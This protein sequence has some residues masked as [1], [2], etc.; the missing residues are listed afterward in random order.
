LLFFDRLYRRRDPI[1]TFNWLPLDYESCKIRA[2]KSPVETKRTSPS[3]AKK[4][5]QGSKKNDGSEVS[6][7]HSN[8]FLSGVSEKV[9]EHELGVNLPQSLGSSHDTK[10][11]LD[12]LYE[13][14]EKAKWEYCIWISTLNRD[15]NFNPRGKIDPNGST[16][17][18]IVNGLKLHF[19]SNTWST[20]IYREDGIYFSW[21]MNSNGHMSFWLNEKLSLELFFRHLQEKLEPCNLTTKEFKALIEGIKH[22]NTENERKRLFKLM[23]K[24]EFEKLK[25][26][27]DSIKDSEMQ[28]LETANII[29]PAGIIARDFNQACLVC[30]KIFFK[31]LYLSVLIKIDKSKGPFEIEFIGPEG[32]TRRLQDVV[33][34]ALQ[35]VESLGQLE[36][37]L[38][39]SI[40][41]LC[42]NNELLVNNSEKLDNIKANLESLQETDSKMHQ[43][44]QQLMPRQELLCEFSE[45]DAHLINLDYKTGLYHYDLKKDL[46][47]LFKRVL[48][49]SLDLADFITSFDTEL[50]K[51]KEEYK[52]AFGEFE[53][54][55][56]TGLNTIQKDVLAAKS[57][58]IEEIKNGVE[59]LK[60]DIKTSSDDLAT[61]IKEEFQTLGEDIQNRMYRLLKVVKIVPKITAKE[62][63]TQLN[64]SQKTVYKYLKKLQEKKLVSS[65]KRSLKGRGRP[66]LVFSLPVHYLFKS[67]KKMNEFK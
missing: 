22:R 66:S 41:I 67:T 24:N 59:V 36:F 31:G 20:I 35:T 47:E 34:R 61:L 29:G 55:V 62:L 28:E 48:T 57:E 65:T 46:S 23:T 3:T 19:K 4:N 6:G 1:I 50:L 33:S 21:S 42:A 49:N 15:H 7:G 64:I 12:K 9:L 26:Q 39:S 16:F 53:E 56:V 8:S 63:S 2:E 5:S 18:K 17:T 37:L 51:L 54:D 38:E 10:L 13:W 45:I 40:E 11:D 32:P 30:K 60:N 25:E 58:V 14:L 43:Q 44:V 52:D 27:L